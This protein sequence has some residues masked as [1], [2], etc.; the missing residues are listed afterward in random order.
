MTQKAY[1]IE[2]NSRNKSNFI[3]CIALIQ[4]MYFNFHKKNTHNIE[5]TVKFMEHCKLENIKLCILIKHPLGSRQEGGGG[6]LV[7]SCPGIGVAQGLENW[8]NLTG[9]TCHLKMGALGL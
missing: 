5:I 1:S 7:T 8:G 9:L 3:T 4:E 2:I 6:T